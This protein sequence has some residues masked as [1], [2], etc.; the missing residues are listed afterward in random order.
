MGRVL[1]VLGTSEG[2]EANVRTE[3]KEVLMNQGLLWVIFRQ[4]SQNFLRIF[5]G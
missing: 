3:R 4:F 2:A 1:M 5:L